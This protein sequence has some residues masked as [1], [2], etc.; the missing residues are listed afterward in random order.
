MTDL[1]TLVEEYLAGRRALGAGLVDA[2]RML[3]K[4]AAFL[5]QRGAACVT[6]EFALEWATQPL[7][8]QPAQWARRLAVVRAFARYAQGTDARHQVPP[9]GLLSAA[10]SQRPR[11]YLYSD[12]E[13]LDLIGAA[14]KLRGRSGLRPRTYASLLA[15]LAVSGMRSSEPLRLDRDDVDLAGGVL[16]VRKSK[17]GKARYVPV[18]ET[19]AVALRTYAQWRDRLCRHPRD[20]AFFLS[21]QGGRIAPRTLQHTFVKLSRQVGLRGPTDSCGPRLHDLR[22]RFAVAAL[23][24]WH[25]EGLDVE[26]RIPHLATYLGHACVSSTYW[27]LTADPELLQLAARRLDRKARGGSS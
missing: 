6:T 7:D 18:H 19:T 17:F 23:R 1:M 3:H 16:T 22:H 12:R 2:G 13:I 11:P 26:S 24:R 20:A 25:R 8:A 21:E 10:E 4:F 9:P 5:A 14:R 15:L 27:Y